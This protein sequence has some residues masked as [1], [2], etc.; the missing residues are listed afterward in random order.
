M[1]ESGRS[2][3][4]GDIE[5]QEGDTTQLRQGHGFVIQVPTLTPEQRA[6]YV[7]FDESDSSSGKEA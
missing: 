2:E 3:D 4:V 6:Q 1:S 5:S 7:V